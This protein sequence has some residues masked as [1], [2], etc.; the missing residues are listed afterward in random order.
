[1][2]Y[3]LEEDKKS[4]S[5]TRYDLSL[6]PKFKT[7]SLAESRVRSSSEINIKI[8]KP[9]DRGEIVESKTCL[10][11]QTRDQHSAGDK[12][13]IPKVFGRFHISDKNVIENIWRC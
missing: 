12:I 3:A 6:T 2:L 5:P 8:V 4:H 7:L 1:M 13:I 11:T 9:V 10:V